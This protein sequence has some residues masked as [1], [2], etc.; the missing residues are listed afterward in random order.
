MISE[1]KSYPNSN[2]A[3]Q[4]NVSKRQ[5]HDEEKR[6]RASSTP[7]IPKTASPLV[8]LSTATL[9][10]AIDR[11]YRELNE[12]KGKADYEL[13]VRSAFQN[14]LA[15]TARL[16]KWTLIP[17]QK[18]EGGIQPDGV[19]RDSFNLRRGYWEA[20]GPKSDLAKEIAKKK[21]DGYPLVNT[22][23]ENTKKAILYQNKKPF[24]VEYDLSKP[25]DISD[26]LRQFF[27]Y[28]E[29]DIENFETAVREFKERIPE[30]AQ[31]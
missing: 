7:E 28:T 11:Y 2:R 20:K 10:K 30:L 15:E 16:V 19:L 31:S 23:F 12:Y 3:R 26:L 29:P 1:L 21:A 6:S 5:Q 22:I 17:E 14:L 27:A 4:T 18:M 9:R 24:P 8:T 13:A 25:N